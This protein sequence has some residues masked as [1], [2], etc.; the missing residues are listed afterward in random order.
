MSKKNILIYCVFT[1]EYKKLIEPWLYFTA[2]RLFPGKADI[3]IITDS[4]TYVKDALSD[5]KDIPFMVEYVDPCKTREEELFLKGYRFLE[6]VY[7]YADKYDFAF[8]IQSNCFLT[9]NIDT[10]KIPLEKNKITVPTHVTYGKNL[11]QKCIEQLGVSKESCAY[12]P[13]DTFLKV[14]YVSTGILG[15]DMQV[16]KEMYAQCHNQ[17]L[18]DKEKNVIKDIKWHDEAYVNYWTTH[19]ETSCIFVPS[20]GDLTILYTNN[21]SDIVN[22]KI[23]ICILDKKGT[24]NINNE[25]T[26][27]P[28]FKYDDDLGSALIKTMYILSL[29]WE[30]RIRCK[31]PA[32]EMP[33]LYK[34]L[35]SFQES[36]MQLEVTSGGYNEF[37]ACRTS[38]EGYSK[39]PSDVVVGAIDYNFISYKYMNKYVKALKEIFKPMQFNTN[40][41]KSIVISLYDYHKFTKDYVISFIRNAWNAILSKLNNGNNFNIDIVIG[42]GNYSD[43]KKVESYR[44]NALLW[45]KEALK[46]FNVDSNIQCTE[47]KIQ[48]E[49]RDLFLYSLMYENKAI[50]SLGN[51]VNWSASYLSESDIVIMSK[52]WK[53]IETSKDKLKDLYPEE[54]IVV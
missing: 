6:C 40:P 13:H 39:I 10:D 26:I 24:F 42:N 12:I 2:S 18:Q 44:N 30:R 8:G 46:E 49:N 20:S 37:I 1:R 9:H 33:K 23:D 22:D 7:K 43:M 50:V 53:G 48:L 27:S 28:I 34:L 14:P 36:N 54:W 11:Y 35:G 16:L 29:S 15:G 31:I 21:M 45:V 19:N 25:D 41:E 32:Y 52:Y 3:L 5:I 51:P 17:Y 47:D 4:K 38:S